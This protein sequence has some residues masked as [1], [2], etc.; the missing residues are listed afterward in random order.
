MRRAT[1]R[2]RLNL[3][4]KRDIQASPASVWSVL[5]DTT[6]WA[7]WGP[8]VRAVACRE[9]FIRRGSRGKVRTPFGVWLPFIVDEYDH[10]HF[11]GWKVAGLRATGHRL[12]RLDEHFSRVVFELP[13]LWFPYAW[14]CRR[15]AHN[16]A[17]LAETG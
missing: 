6:Q 5:T 1:T 12:I 10:L 7:H 11:W 15:A 8:S 3:A 17:R 13:P 16:L 9:R 4:V 2:P 14:I